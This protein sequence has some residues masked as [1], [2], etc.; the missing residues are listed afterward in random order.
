MFNDR[1]FA[2]HN[3]ERLQHYN[4]SLLSSQA[5]LFQKKLHYQLSQSDKEDISQ[6]KIDD[7]TQ[8]NIVCSKK[9]SAF[10]LAF[11]K[12]LTKTLGKLI[13]NKFFKHFL[14]LMIMVESLL[15]GICVNT[16]EYDAAIANASQHKCFAVFQVCVTVL[17]FFEVLTKLIT[18]FKNFWKS[19]WNVFEFF[20]FK[21]TFICQVVDF[22]LVF[23]YVDMID[24]N[25]NEN[26]LLSLLKSLKVF[27]I[28]KNLRLLSH[29]VELRIIIICLTRAIRSV[30][31]ISMLL[32]IISFLF[33]KIGFVLFSNMDQAN[34]LILGDCFSSIA[35]ALITLFAI[36]TLDQ[37]WKIFSTVSEFYNK[38]YLTTFY[39][40][41]WLILASFIFQNLFTGIM[42]NN[43]QEIRKD[44]VQAL[45]IKKI[46][47][48]KHNSKKAK[49]KVSYV[50]TLN[51]TKSKSSS[52]L[53][54][55]E[56]K[57]RF[58]NHLTFLSNKR[59]KNQKHIVEKTNLEKLNQVLQKMTQYRS[60]NQHWNDLMNENLDLLK[61]IQTNALWPEESL[62][63]YYELMVIL[64]E[65]LKERMVLLN[66]SNQ[67]LLKLH[68]R[69][70]LFFPFEFY[71]KS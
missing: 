17:Y 9:K 8:E 30:V 19:P 56:F 6:E 50:N 1:N 26:F 24:H 18:D 48:K 45:V 29:F 3:N 4:T 2:N 67:S 7:L 11:I 49:N 55:V 16:F 37:W 66:Y 35:E 54:E 61:S 12:I 63:K 64:M 52:R 13:L 69:D 15:I 31:L 39:F 68:D 57:N 40:V 62:I 20:L 21:L 25:K 10:S 46:Q 71:N 41:A 23:K 53:N 60:N 5:S 44:V 51:P 33:A 28:L 43:F 22:I 42:V 38:Y 58:I 47:K 59:I 36:M 14:I 34:D 65:N 70:N 27:R 32:L